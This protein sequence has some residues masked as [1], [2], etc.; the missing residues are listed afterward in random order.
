MTT[1][2]TIVHVRFAPDGS[3]ME[4]G[5]RPAGLAAQQWYDRLSERFG[6]AFQALAGGRGVLRVAKD[7]LGALKADLEVLKA[8]E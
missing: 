6:S 2:A 5:E 4:I 1:N 7:D 8:A 3:V